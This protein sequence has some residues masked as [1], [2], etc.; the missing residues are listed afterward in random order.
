[1]MSSLCSGAGHRPYEVAH[2]VSQYRTARCIPQPLQVVLASSNKR[3]VPYVCPGQLLD[4]VIE[5]P[6]L[7]AKVYGSHAHLKIF[8]SLSRI[9]MPAVESG[10]EGKSCSE[11]ESS[12]QRTPSNGH[13]PCRNKLGDC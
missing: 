2:M 1:M 7:V 10:N 3:L 13:H 9:C 6:H 8:L 11:R 5:Q 12:E 4:E